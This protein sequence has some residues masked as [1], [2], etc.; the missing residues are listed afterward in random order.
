MLDG[1]EVP[2]ARVEFCGEGERLLEVWLG[3][4]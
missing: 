3:D 2:R 1:D 4:S